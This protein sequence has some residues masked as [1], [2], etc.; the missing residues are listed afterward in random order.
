MAITKCSV[1]VDNI[2]QLGDRPNTDNQLTA[3]ALK[4]KVEYVEGYMTPVAIVLRAHS[5]DAPQVNSIKASALET[6][7]DGSYDPYPESYGGSG[8]AG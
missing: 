3:A 1:A 5:D 7:W 4:Q 8:T 6:F 2:Q